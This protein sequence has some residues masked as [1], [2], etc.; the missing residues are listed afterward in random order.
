ME[1]EFWRGGNVSPDELEVFPLSDPEVVDVMQFASF[2]V[3]RADLQVWVASMSDVAGC[4]NL[5]RPVRAEPG[6]T[7]ADADAPELMLMEYLREAGWVP[8]DRH[9]PHSLHDDPG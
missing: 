3:M 8:G 1:L 6:L 2:S 9:G 7:I 5:S 4:V